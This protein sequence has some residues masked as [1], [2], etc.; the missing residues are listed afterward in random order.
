MAEFASDNEILRAFHTVLPYLP[1]YFDH[2]ASIAITDTEK[3]LYDQPCS[4][5]PVNNQPGSPIPSGGAAFR[6]IQEGCPVVRAVPKEVYGVAF[7][8]YA[9]P[10]KDKGQVVGCVMVAKS[11]SRRD[12]LLNYSRHFRRFLTS[13]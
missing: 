8:S 9:V 3:Y 1:E 10:I 13:P 2:E 6:A 11:L 7:K 4:A 5:V 12:D